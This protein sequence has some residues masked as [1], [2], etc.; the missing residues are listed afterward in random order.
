[1]I[2]CP[3][4]LLT[5]GMKTMSERIMPRYP[6]YV[7]SKGRAKSG[8]TVRALLAGGCPFYLVV[9]PQE[10]AIYRATFPD[11]TLLILPWSGDDPVRRAFCQEREIEN[12]GLIAVRNW[13]KEHA[14]AAGAERHWQ[15]DDN[16]WDFW[17]RYR[18][19]RLPCEPGIAL[20]VC[21]DFTDRYENI[22]ISGL[23]YEMF[24]PDYNKL[25]PL[26]IN[27]R[28]YSCSLILNSL[29]FRWRLAYNDDT[30]I[31]LQALAAGWCTVLLNTFL[32]RKMRTMVIKGGNTADLYQGDGRLK[33]ARSL[34]R[35]WPGVVETDRRF[36]RPQHVVKDSWKRFDTPLKLKPGIDLAQLPAVNEYG[37]ELRQVKDTVKSKRIQGL[38][39]DWQETHEEP[40]EEEEPPG[41]GQE[42]Q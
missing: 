1:M 22:A 2:V 4:D 19:K 39:G 31:C 17:R 23:N 8:L 33:M 10:E 14:V 25:Q 30:D 3:S 27:C 12:G 16:I 13:I 15:L 18:G 26:V 5:M 36:H 9:E 38:L 37:M 32:A 7:P 28:V 24:A 6:V 29:P 20:R 11:A 41:D 40:G 21:E 42:T 34:E 35:A